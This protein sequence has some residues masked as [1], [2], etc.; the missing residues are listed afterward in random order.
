MICDDGKFSFIL[1]DDEKKK[2]DMIF[3]VV[4]LVRKPKQNGKGMR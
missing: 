4:V 1:F 3:F 2:K